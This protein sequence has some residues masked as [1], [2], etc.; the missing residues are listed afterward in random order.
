MTN[1]RTENRASTVRRFCVLDSPVLPVQADQC[2]LNGRGEIDMVFPSFVIEHERGVAMIDT[3]LRPESAD[4]P[5][6]AYGPL[7]EALFPKGWN[8][9]LG[10]DRQLERLGYGLADIETVIM[11]HL[12]FDHT[13]AMR[14][15]SHAQFIGGVGEMRYAWWPDPANMM[16]GFYLTD[17][18]AFLRDHPEQWLE[19]GPQDHDV[20]GDGSVVLFHLPGHTPGHLATL[21]RT[22]DQNIVL[23]NDVVHVRAGLAGWPMPYD[24]NAAETVAS[25][26]RL[27]AL[28]RAYDATLWV[29][30]DIDDWHAMQSFVGRA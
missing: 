15:F 14:L 11:S 2:V 26:M 10:V 13:G 12:H 20:F 16:A 24:W 3:G 7:G 19:V 5:G 17:D 29:P 27:K 6:G 28:A 9:D 4:D 25:I 30:H 1:T 22:E 8:R 21:V 23:A 18:F